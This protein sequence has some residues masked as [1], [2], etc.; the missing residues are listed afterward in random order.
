M[1]RNL[2]S[3]C[4]TCDNNEEGFDSCTERCIVPYDIL[5]EIEDAR[6]TYLEAKNTIKTIQDHFV[7]NLFT[8]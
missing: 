8:N 3:M 1:K 7:N 6:S 5:A 2:C 4:E